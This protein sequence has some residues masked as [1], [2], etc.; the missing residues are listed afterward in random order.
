VEVKE[1]IALSISKVVFR[2]G[3]RFMLSVTNF[4]N[5]GQFTLPEVREGLICLV[6][7]TGVP[8]DKLGYGQRR[9]RLSLIWL[10]VCGLEFWKRISS[11]S[12]S[13]LQ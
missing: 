3:L 10:S 2:E 6:A 5:L 4:L 11:I 12:G 1:R 13:L 8:Q 7:Q 9:D